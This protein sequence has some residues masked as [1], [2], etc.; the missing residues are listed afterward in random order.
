[1]KAEAEAVGDVFQIRLVAGDEYE[2][3]VLKV[4]QA[5]MV[6][7]KNIPIRATIDEEKLFLTFY[8]TL[9]QK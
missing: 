3:G 2:L 9:P 1:M 6:T 5:T 7:W 8:L 4:L